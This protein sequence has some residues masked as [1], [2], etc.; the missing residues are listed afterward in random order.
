MNKRKPK[1]RPHPEFLRWKVHMLNNGFNP[2][3]Y[4]FRKTVYEIGDIRTAF[5]KRDRP[6]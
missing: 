4:P 2:L 5:V 1:Q 6:L 3:E